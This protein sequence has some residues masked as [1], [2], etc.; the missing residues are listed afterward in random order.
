MCMIATKDGPKTGKRQECRA[1][2]TKKGSQEDKVSENGIVRVCVC[3]R[4]KVFVCVCVKASVS[5]VPSCELQA[6]LEPFQRRGS[7]FSNS[8]LDFYCG[9]VE[10]STAGWNICTVSGMN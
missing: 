1:M 9:S 6:L 5:S 8:Q 2:R 3:V 7:I 10:G 4:V